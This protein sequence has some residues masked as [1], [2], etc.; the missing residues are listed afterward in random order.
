MGREQVLLL[1]LVLFLTEGEDVACVHFGVFCF[2]CSSAEERVI[3]WEQTD[4]APLDLCQ[5]VV[6]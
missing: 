5:N 1:G 3:P 6:P 4:A 2:S